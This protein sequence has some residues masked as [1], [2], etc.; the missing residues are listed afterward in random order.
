VLR[1][2]LLGKSH[3]RAGFD[4][5]V[6]ALDRYLR[7]TARQHIQKGIAKTFVLVDESAVLPKPVL[8]FFT[9][10]LCQ[11]VCE[12]VP[13]KWARKLPPQIPAMRLGR[14]AVLRTRQGEG[15]GRVLL[16]EAI[17]KVASV[18]DAAGGIG[19]FVD[20]KDEAA[21]RFYARFGFEP[22]P[23]GALTL[24]LPM[25]TLRQFLDG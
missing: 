25:A 23:T 17:T 7:E 21:A 9:V 4:S 1:V 16:V 2:E 19:L 18:A 5:G 3:D 22:T 8:G 12:G 20:A 24:F 15:L 6:P 14:L 13:P 11:V 10:S